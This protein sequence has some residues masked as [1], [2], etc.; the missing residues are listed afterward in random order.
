LQLLDEYQRA[1]EVTRERLYIETLEVVLASNPKVI[2][3]VE[4]G[5]NLTYLPLDKIMSDSSRTT[6]S[7]TA[8][9]QLSGTQGKGS[10]TTRN[11]L[12]E[13]RRNTARSRIRETR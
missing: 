3:D 6:G 5:N 11:T 4:N 7:G 13:F 8:V 9:R 10:A 1:P 12:D 2:L